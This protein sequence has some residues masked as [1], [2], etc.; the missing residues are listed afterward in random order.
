MLSGL[1]A[2]GVSLALSKDLLVSKDLVVVGTCSTC[3]AV[4]HETVED[5]AAHTPCH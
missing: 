1:E 3:A 2:T 4:V 5:H